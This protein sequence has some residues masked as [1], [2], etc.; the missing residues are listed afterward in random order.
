MRETTKAYTI[1]VEK[2][3]G[4]IQPGR[5][6]LIWVNSVKTCLRETGWGGGGLYNEL[7][8]LIKW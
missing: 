3:D 7:I 5:P 1:F 2:P 8:F 6:R 4:K